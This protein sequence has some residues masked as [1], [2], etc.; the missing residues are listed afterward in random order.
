MNLDSF[1]ILVVEFETKGDITLERTGMPFRATG[2][3]YGLADICVWGS[4]VEDATEKFRTVAK[5]YFEGH[6][7]LSVQVI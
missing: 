6:G 5:G 3:L 7:V 2:A 4:S 1:P